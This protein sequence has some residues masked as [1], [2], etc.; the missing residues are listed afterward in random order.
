MAGHTGKRI[1]WD[2]PASETLPEASDL[3]TLREWLYRKVHND[4]WPMAETARH[5]GCA[6]STLQ[7]ALERRQCPL[8]ASEE[9]VQN[10]A[11]EP[12]PAEVTD[13]VTGGTEA[14]TTRAV[15]FCW[16]CDKPFPWETLLEARGSL[17]C[18]DC[19]RSFA[20][21]TCDVE[22][23]AS[24]PSA[25]VAICWNCG[26]PSPEEDIELVDGDTPYCPECFRE[27]CA[28]EASAAA[29]GEACDAV[30]P[31][32][33]T[34]GFR[35]PRHRGEALLPFDCAIDLVRFCRGQIEDGP[36]EAWGFVRGWLARHQ[37]EAEER[38]D[39]PGR[40]DRQP[41]LLGGDEA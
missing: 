30:A 35:L 24:D 9:L 6:W 21:E 20:G 25:D 11:E 19:Y 37:R 8:P 12:P 33:A 18:P 2:G 15:G 28:R 5:I 23:P 16:R 34:A 1:N 29:M 27:L 4:G 14:P 17:Y 40:V 13:D 26:K 7:N 10:A 38:Q 41:T 22:D 32:Q 31:S 3:L 36:D 39:A